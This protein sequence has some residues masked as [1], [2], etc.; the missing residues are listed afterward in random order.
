M[1]NWTKLTFF[2]GLCYCS[3]LKLTHSRTSQNVLH[4]LII[5]SNDFSIY[6]FCVYRHLFLF[7]NVFLGKNC[8]FPSFFKHDDIFNFKWSIFHLTIFQTKISHSDNM[9]KQKCGGHCY[10][11]YFLL[12]E[13]LFLEWVNSD[14][15][16]R[17]T[18][19][20]C[21]CRSLFVCLLVFHSSFQQNIVVNEKFILFCSVSSS[22][23]LG[24][25]TIVVE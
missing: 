1:L 14:H 21:L 9:G 18:F 25:L 6:S 7:L 17:Y 24:K 19:L 15:F 13:F 4:L 12:L 3:M 16:L 10:C 20:C 8:S 23:T 5:L 22:S 2:N 11:G